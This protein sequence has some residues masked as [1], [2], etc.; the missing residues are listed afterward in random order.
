MRLSNITLPFEPSRLPLMERRLA[1]E[2]RRRDEIKTLESSLIDFVRQGWGYIDPSEYADCYAI[3]ALCEHLQAVTEG[4]I[5]RLLVNFP[6]RCG[7]SLV[8]SVC[9][10]V[11]TWARR[12]QGYLSGPGVQFLTG[13][14]NHDLSLKF[15]NLS[16]RLI[17][18]PWF[19][20]R[21]GKRVVLRDDQNT[22][23]Q[24]DT[25]A[26]G[27]RI[28]TSVG[29][30]LIG[31]GGAVICVDDPHNTET[32]E[33]E[34]ERETVTNW[35]RE[36]SS[37]RLNDPKQSAIVVIMQRLHEEDVSGQILGSENADEW[38]HLCL[39]MR[40]EEVR[41]CVTSIG[42]ED[43]R[44]DDGELLWP[45]RYG[46][47]EVSALEASL[48]PYMASGRLQQLPT[49]AGG[50][51]FRRE[52][53]QVWE[54]TDGK[55]PTCD[56]IVASLD[57]AYTEK[58]ENDPSGFTVWGVFHPKHLMQ[59]PTGK[60]VETEMSPRIILMD[61]WRKH[62]Q[63]H[64]VPVDYTADEEEDFRS[65]DEDRIKAARKRYEF[66]AKPHWGLVEW[67]AHSCRRFN[68]D[69]LLIEA[70]ASG[71]DVAHEM[72]RLYGDE[73]WAVHENPVKGDKV[74][75]AHAVVPIFTQGLVYAPDRDWAELVITE[76][77]SFP[78]GR[79][80]DLTD[81]ATQALKH[82]REGG[83]AETPQERARADLRRA[84]HRRK[85]G[86]LYPV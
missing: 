84:Q 51:I 86:K 35:W 73:R 11:W 13:S 71:L 78:K 67:V 80:K 10:P 28:A 39:P 31:I 5:K 6:P 66:R 61:A 48:G 19:Q 33:S 56:Y 83:M 3:D 57:S 65:G 43:W 53:W 12:E 69:A 37:T 54:P 49:P 17:L 8:T 77:E 75:R 60:M 50:A 24:Y 20:A 1:E 70:K 40:Y 45:E 47:K 52:W 42:W 41:H 46:E 2:I 38:T 68:V 76:M 21:W 81:S 72:R 22:K 26:G 23:T 79:F 27:S 74:S 7:K 64:G 9:W 63:I 14:Y 44:R 36:L 34:A 59:L 62:L 30:S 82:I 85:M 25:D 29:G 16:R 55:F 58:E 4:Q 18:S 15:S 32:V